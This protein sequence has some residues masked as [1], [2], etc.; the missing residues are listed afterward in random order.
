MNGR[1]RLQLNTSM[2]LYIPLAVMTAFYLIPLYIMLVTGFKSF[3]EVDLQTMWNL[4]SGFHVDNFVAAFGT[5]APNL[6]NSFMLVIPAAILSS[7]VGS[8]NGFILAKWKFPGADIIFP[9]LLFGMFI[10][11]QSILIPLVEFMRTVNLY[12]TLPGLI[13]THI[14]YGIPIT[15]LTFRNY[16]ATLPREVLESAHIDGAGM[17]QIYRSIVLPLSPPAFVVVLIWQFTSAWNDFLFAVV[18]TDSQT[19]PVTVALNNMA[20]SQIIAWNVQMAGSFLAALPTLLVYIF[21]GRFF[22]RGLM[23]GALKG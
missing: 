20:G 9:V 14:I 7:F 10:P 17:L 4:P 3:E 15:T 19:W 6:T 22:I 2:W 5:L 16:Y 12:G 18:L 13:L 8:I 23:A 11:Y 21:L 1:S